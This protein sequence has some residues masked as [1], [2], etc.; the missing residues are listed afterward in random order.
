MTMVALMSWVE[1]GTW[2]MLRGREEMVKVHRKC[3][4]IIYILNIRV[5]T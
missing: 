5:K 2:R 1:E 3:D 4:V